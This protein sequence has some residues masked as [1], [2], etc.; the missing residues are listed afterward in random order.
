MMINVDNRLI[1]VATK[2]GQ[3]I[4]KIF[5]K[6]IFNWGTMFWFLAGEPSMIL[7]WMYRYYILILVTA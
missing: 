6:N 5:L 1:T 7:H 4:K 2:Q 3:E